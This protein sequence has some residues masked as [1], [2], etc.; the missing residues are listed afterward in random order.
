M[1]RLRWTPHPRGDASNAQRY[2]AIELLMLDL[3]VCNSIQSM[4]KD[5]RS[6]IIVRVECLGITGRQEHRHTQGEVEGLVGGVVVS[7]YDSDGS[8]CSFPASPCVV[9]GGPP[10]RSDGGGGGK[11]CIRN[12]RPNEHGT[13]IK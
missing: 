2:Y 7:L 4:V 11:R 3:P 5:L 13:Q 1:H 6:G 9:G 12:E 8:C 10:G